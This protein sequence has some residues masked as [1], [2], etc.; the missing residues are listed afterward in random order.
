MENIPQNENI[1]D[2]NANLKLD[3][4]LV[5]WKPNYILSRASLGQIM[6]SFNKI[7]DLVPKNIYEE[8]LYEKLP[9]ILKKLIQ[10]YE[11]ILKCNNASEHCV[12]YFNLI[13]NLP[14][15]TSIFDGEHGYIKLGYPKIGQLIKAANQR[16]DYILERDD[17]KFY[18]ENEILLKEF[19]KMKQEIDKFKDTLLDFEI[20]FME[21]INDAHKMQRQIY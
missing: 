6:C 9:V 4:S 13:G 18:Q 21:A 3:L 19:N 2:T 12:K 10:T 15:G 20:D 17:P 8:T 5:H 11:N 16:I 14:K 1:L 7:C